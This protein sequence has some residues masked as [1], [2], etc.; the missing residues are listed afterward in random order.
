[1]IKAIVVAGLISGVF[2]VAA[3]DDFK[4]PFPEG[5]RRWTFLH[6]TV[7]GANNGSLGKDKCEKPCTGGI[8]YFY[9]NDKAMEG[10]RTGRFPEGSIIADELLETEE[11][12]ERKSAKE[13]RR[14]G[15]GVMAKDSNRYA[16][17]GGWGYA[18]FDGDS[19]V[20]EN[21][22]AQKKACF[23]CHLPR[24]DQDYV[25]SHYRER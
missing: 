9:A 14:R 8:M 21:T 13:G 16:S 3:S 5:Y 6:G 18:S 20:D 25:F 1:M 4:V 10:F 15:V 17:T 12:P 7:I 2:A 23:Q 24:K 22:E 11:Q 19:K